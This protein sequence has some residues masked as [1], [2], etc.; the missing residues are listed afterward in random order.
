MEYLTASYIVLIALFGLF[1][2][3]FLNVVAIRTL[4][5][6][7]LSLPPSH[8]MHCNHRLGPLDLVP[9]L[10]YLLLRGK[11]RYCRAEISPAYAIWETTTALLFGLLAWQ[12]GPTTELIVALFFASI[13]VVIVQTDFRE[14]I[15]PDRVVYFA[16]AV[17]FLLRIIIHPLPLWN[18]LS[19]FLIGGGSLFLIAIV[20]S[21]IFK[22]DAMGGGDI[23]LLAFVGLIL[24]IQLTLLTIFLASL[25]GTLY[26][27]L[28]IVLRRY[29]RNKYI[30]FGPFIAAGSLIAYLWGDS[31]IEWYVNCF[32]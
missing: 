27:L 5:K 22:K 29:N 25:I 31:W 9:V 8:C 3:S 32:L 11:C 12:L 1:I 30:P 28:L 17:G 7:S 14:M 20:G 24:G 6:E 2:G 13:L 21:A 4:K 16:M 18:H 19:A 10:S 15:I 23:K 26:G